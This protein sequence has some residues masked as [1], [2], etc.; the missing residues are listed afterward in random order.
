MRQRSSTT[1]QLDTR[2]TCACFGKMAADHQ[3]PCQLQQGVAWRP[4][5]AW[6][7]VWHPTSQA[8]GHKLPCGHDCLTVPGGHHHHHNAETLPR[9]ASQTSQPVGSTRGFRPARYQKMMLFWQPKHRAHSVDPAASL[10][11]QPERNNCTEV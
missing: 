6:H 9:L 8:N 11:A 4:G 1:Q 7:G 3:S 10:A 2:T 5:G